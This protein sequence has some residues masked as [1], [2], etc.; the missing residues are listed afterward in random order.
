MLGRPQGDLEYR[1]LLGKAGFVLT[2]VVPTDSAVS[3]VEAKPAT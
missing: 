3:V 1:T 2:R